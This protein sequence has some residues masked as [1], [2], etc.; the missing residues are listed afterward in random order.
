MDLLRDVQQCNQKC[1]FWMNVSWTDIQIRDECMVR[2]GGQS[3]QYGAELQEMITL[4]WFYFT[5]IS[6]WDHSC[7]NRWI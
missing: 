2:I 3:E 7:R 4:K 1:T 5:M 6:W